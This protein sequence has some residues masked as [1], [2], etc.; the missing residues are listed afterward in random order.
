M[1]IEGGKFLDKKYGDLTGSR[2]VERAVARARLDE[3]RDFAP[4]TREERVE[5]YLSRLENI[6]KDDRGWRLLKQKLLK[7]LTIDTDDEEVVAKIARGL[8]EAEKRIAIN[9]GRGADIE[10]LSDDEV[11]PQYTKAVYEKREIQ[12]RSL[13]AWLDYLEKNDAHHPTWFRYFVVRNLDKMGTLNK[14]KGEYSKRTD[15]TVA[16]FPE[17]NS[18]ALGFVYRMLTTGV[19]SQ[20]YVLDLQETP[21]QQAETTQKLATLRNLIEKKDFAKLYVFAQIETAGALNRESLQGEWRKFEQGSDYRVLENSLK[22]KGT[23]WCTAEGSASAHVRD[24]DFYVYFTR[25]AAGVYSEPRIAIRMEGDTVAEVRGVNHRQE[26]EPALVEVAQAQYKQ[27]PGG[28]R[29]D[30]KS[31]DMKQVTALVQK[32]EKNISFTKDDLRFLYELDGTIEG[33]GYDDDPRIVELRRGRNR[34]Q[35]IET[36]CDCTPEYIAT[37]IQDLNEETQVFCVD[38]GDKISFVDFREAKNQA[39]LLQIIEFNKAFKETGSPARLDVAIEG[40]IVPLELTQDNLESLQ[41]YETAIKAYEKADGGSPSWVWEPLQ[42]I[43]WTP[44]NRRSLAVHILDHGRTNEAE[45]DQLVADMDNAGYRVLTFS[46]LVALG[47][48]KPELNKRD[49]ILNTYEKHTLHGGSRVPYLY[50]D[51]GGRRL[52][53][54]HADADWGAH[55][56]F[57][58]VRK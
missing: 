37:D 28:E 27:L 46:E 56:R 4:H 38:K 14:E 26:L 40:G 18:E 6:I 5:A 7:E 13:S 30:K 19:G 3:E 52:R 45:R 51:G 12:E 2:E 54:L 15:Y 31:A 34:Q 42:N 17:L 25:S 10:R 16:P 35:D 39:K 53:A 21:E 55:Y 11:L 20:E 23:G 47:V 43:P 32:Q 49:E 22:G 29:F 48:S 9:Q 58:F 50:W 1:G 41:N 33:F 8:Y 24:G 44:P 36:M 57:L